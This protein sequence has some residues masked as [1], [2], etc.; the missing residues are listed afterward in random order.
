ALDVARTLARAPGI[1][2]ATT[3]PD[4]TARLQP[5]AEA[6]RRENDV[7][8]VVFMSADGIRFTHPDP[9]LIGQHFRGH[10]E[11]AVRGEVSTETYAGSLGPSV[12][13]VVPVLGAPGARP[14]ALVSVGVTEHRIDALVRDDIPLVILGAAGALA[15]A[16]GAGAAVH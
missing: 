2:E 4:A 14:I 1:G 5:I 8:F 11:S 6:V 13:A 9:T 15:V 16:C 10:I 7:D 3:A 12:R